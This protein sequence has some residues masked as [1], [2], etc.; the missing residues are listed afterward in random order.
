M[1]VSA[2][3]EGTVR[4]W[5]I[6]PLSRLDYPLRGH[7]GPID[8]LALNPRTGSLVSAGDD[9]RLR[10]RNTDKRKQLGIPLLTHAGAVADVAVTSDGR[11][12]ASAGQDGTVQ[13]WSALTRKQ[14]GAMQGEAKSGQWRSARTTVRSP[15]VVPTTRSG[16]GISAPT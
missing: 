9:G 10:L 2:G 4:I 1:L 12:M 7:K 14:L 13:L 15:R 3:S 6:S 11:T 16:C 8:G 5:A